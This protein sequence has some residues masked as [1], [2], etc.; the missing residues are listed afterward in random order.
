MYFKTPAEL[1]RY[2]REGFTEE[3]L[4][5]PGAVFATVCHFF[6]TC[7]VVTAGRCKLLLAL[8]SSKSQTF[9]KTGIEGG[10][11]FTLEEEQM[12]ELDAV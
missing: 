1:I 11:S 7:T 10:F 12:P 2:F 4:K 8:G 3:Y 5:A 6:N 9:I